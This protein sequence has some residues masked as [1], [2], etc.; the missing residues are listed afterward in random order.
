MMPEITEEKK[1][2][3][4]LCLSTEWHGEYETDYWIKKNIYLFY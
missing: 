3:V 1:L 4:L 2:Q